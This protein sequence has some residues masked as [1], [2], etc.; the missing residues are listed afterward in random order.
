VRVGQP[1]KMDP[2]LRAVSLDA[3]VAETPLGKRAVRLR[4][5]AAKGAGGAAAAAAGGGGRGGGGRGGG[6]GDGATGSQRAGLWAAASQAEQLA[7]RAVLD[8]AR[9][10]AATCVGAG[11]PRLDGR[12][13]AVVLLDEATQATEP[14]AL[15]ALAGR[16]QAAVLVGDQAQ[17]PPT[18]RSARALRLGL[19]DSLFERLLRMGARCCLLDTQYRMHP[20]IAAFPSRAFY[21]GRLASAP[22]GADRPPVA[23]LRWPRP[24][25]P[26]VFL[27]VDGPE[28]RASMMDDDDGGGGG[29]GGGRPL[30]VDAEDEA[31]EDDEEDGG[32]EGRG[33]EGGGGQAARRARGRRG[34]PSSK[35]LPLRVE[36][37]SFSY[38]NRAEA[39]V[40]LAAL[41]AALRAADGSDGAAGPA[42]APGGGD[43]GGGGAPAAAAAV[44]LRDAG[45]VCVISPY[46]GQVR[47]VS[48]AL[49][50][51]SASAE[52]AAP[53]LEDAGGGGDEQQQHQ[54]HQQQQAPPPPPPRVEVRSVDGFQGRER[55]LVV[56]SAVR[57]NPSGRVGFLSDARRLNVAL[58]R[59]RRGLVVVGDARTLARGDPTWRAWLAWARRE[60]VLLGAPDEVAR[61]VGRATGDEGGRER[62]GGGGAA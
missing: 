47:L 30:E 33:A 40:V 58:T 18:V 54:Q 32:G 51:S 57:S 20:A 38:E 1:A 12:A 14:A 61:F 4:A 26:V 31:G 15:V 34:L 17:L 21:G 39:A 44:A 43:D 9:V 55:E 42:P 52:G 56:F 45:D 23:G 19:G 11:E 37:S 8:G 3:I 28:R 13:F 62:G 25:V 6:G 60:G 29:G 27:Q 16:A 35:A 2:A 50:A 24:E 36:P 5:Q 59:A 46:A 7:S 48:A 10:V 22:R 49:L 41:Q 53:A